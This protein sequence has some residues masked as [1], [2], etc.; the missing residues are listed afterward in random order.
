ML[1]VGAFT[2]HFGGFNEIECYL[3]IIC[4]FYYVFLASQSA[5]AN[6]NNTL[7]EEQIR[8]SLLSAVEDKMK[9]RLREILAQAQV[10]KFDQLTKFVGQADVD[11]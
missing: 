7:S 6:S 11:D 5:V 9:R 1:I 8:L 4:A 10:D 3:L 2:I